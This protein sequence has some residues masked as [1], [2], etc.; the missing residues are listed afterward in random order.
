MTTIRHAR[1]AASQTGRQPGIATG[2]FTG[3]RIQSG[4]LRW[5]IQ[6]KPNLPEMVYRKGFRAL[7]GNRAKSCESPFQRL[8]I[9]RLQV[10]FLPRTRELRA[11][12]VSRTDGRAGKSRGRSAPSPR[13]FMYMRTTL[14]PAAFH[15]HP[16]AAA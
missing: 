8:L 4:E 14:L 7:V 15:Q 11:R 2:T 3:T 5:V 6:S 12:A 9:G 16:S 1:A 10:R 13:E